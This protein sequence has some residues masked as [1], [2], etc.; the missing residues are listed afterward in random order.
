MKTF[1]HSSINSWVKNVPMNQY[2]E[3]LPILSNGNSFIKEYGR[4]FVFNGVYEKL[5]MSIDILADR[6]G[7]HRTS[8][9]HQNKT[10]YKEQPDDQIAADF[11]SKHAWEYDV[12]D[13]ALDNLE[14]YG[15][16]S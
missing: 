1:T 12:Y 3:N 11:K 7:R 6:L 9:S 4:T 14:S 15:Y 16:D 8:I 13:W 5:Q 2:R 10:P